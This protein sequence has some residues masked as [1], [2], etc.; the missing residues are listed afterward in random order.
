[1]GLSERSRA[2]LDASR[3]RESNLKTRKNLEAELMLSEEAS[4]G[5]E[6][7]SG[8]EANDCFALQTLQR[9]VEN[10]RLLATADR[11]EIDSLKRALCAERQAREK[12]EK[13]LFKTRETNLQLQKKVV[14]LKQL[15]TSREDENSNTN[16]K[17]PVATTVTKSTYFLR[18]GCGG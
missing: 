16:V 12:C 13:Q 7:A 8:D 1:M 5:D 3:E 6:E 14:A 18:T 9:S 17:K 10:L 11:A 15:V 2:L 4:S